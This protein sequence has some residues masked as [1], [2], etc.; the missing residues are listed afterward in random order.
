MNR[1]LL[2]GALA[3]SLL[4]GCGIREPLRPAEG[5]SLPPAPALATRQLTS[6]QLLAVSPEMRPTRVDEPLT[7]SEQRP[8]DR[9]DLPP[10][11]VGGET[12]ADPSELEDEPATASSP[13]Q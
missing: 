13:P 8:V 10:P 1:L 3:A 2:A 6:E 11:D 7:R 9:F 4:A 12:E 5:Q